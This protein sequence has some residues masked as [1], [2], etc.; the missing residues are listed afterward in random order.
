MDIKTSN[1][2]TIDAGIIFILIGIM[3]IM[4]ATSWWHYVTFICGII[5]VGFGIYGYRNNRRF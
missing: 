3:K 2:I 1:M 5:M 4:N